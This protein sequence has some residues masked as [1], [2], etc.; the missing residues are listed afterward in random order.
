[1]NEAVRWVTDHGKII[2]YSLGM[3]FVIGAMVVMVQTVSVTKDLD[4]RV[5]ELEEHPVINHTVVETVVG[6]TWKRN[7]TSGTSYNA[8]ETTHYNGSAYICVEEPCTDAP[9]LLTHWDLVASKGEKGD[10]GPTG[11]TGSTGDQGVQGLQGETGIQGPVGPPGPIGLEYQGY[12]AENV[13]YLER[14]AVHHDG[15]FWLCRV[16]GTQGIEPVDNITEWSLLVVKGDP[17]IQ[18]VMGP[19][20]ERGP[21]GPPGL[22]FE[23]YWNASVTYNRSNVVSHLGTAYACVLET[24]E[25]EEP[26]IYA[27]ETE[28]MLL[29]TKGDQGIQGIKGDQGIQGVAGEPGFNWK[30][31]WQPNV[32]YVERDGVHHLGSS[33]LCVV[34]TSLGVDPS[35]EN[36]SDWSLFTEKGDTGDVGPTGAQG[37]QGVPGPAGIEMEGAWNSTVTYFQRDA[38]QHLGSLYGCVVATSLGVEPT[39]YA[40]N[41]D[42]TLLVEKGEKGD[43]GVPGEQGEQGVP[44]IQGPAGEDGDSFSFSYTGESIRC[45]CF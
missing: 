24:C 41:T 30:A 19:I 32:T 40:N 27:N 34:E 42:W 23:G 26:T 37:A 38:V 18:G 2:L 10:I 13:T 3:A 17:G 21:Q 11:L 7:W 35:W 36:Q 29:A 9:H 44:G 8:A 16:N 45:V 25:N 31:F 22:T 12:W 15:S 33:Y 43:Q 6:M 39:P 5:D 1:M 28:W 14:D 20:G 4:D